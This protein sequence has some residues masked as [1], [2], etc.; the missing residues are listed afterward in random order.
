[1]NKIVIIG[2]GFSGLV[3]AISAK[4]DNNEVTILEKRNIVG[5][6]ILVTGNGRCNYYNEVQ[7]NKFYHS[8]NE[9]FVENIKDE[10]HKVLE[11]YNNLGI[12][13]FIKDGYY[14]PYSK[15]ASTI[16]NALENRCKELNIKI[17]TDYKVDSV[18]KDNNEFVIN[19]DIRC[20][21]VII[22]TGSLAYYKDEEQSLGYDIAKSFGHHIVKLLPSL[23]Q[24]KGEGNYFKEWAGVRSDAIVSLYVDNYLVSKE[25]GEVM[26][27]DYG[28]SG[29]CIFN[30]SGHASRSLDLGM[31]V[32]I[33]INFLPWLTENVYKYLNNRDR[34]IENVL[35]GM[36]N[37]KL[38][39]LIL[40]KTNIDKNK[41]FKELRDEDKDILVDYL[42]NFKVKITGVNGFDKA[43]VCSGGV[44]TKEVDKNTY[45]SKLVKGLYFAG[46]I[47]DVDGI[48][49]GYNITFATLSGIKAGIGAA[50]D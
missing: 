47:L 10:T 4:K 26:L 5:K 8:S 32:R 29:I 24:L 22:A 35:E 48:C 34:S 14:Y 9:E 37:S 27:T 2:G 45:E 11:F 20:N 12:V 3:S 7:D 13:P 18:I 6:K 1:M 42:L 44:D 21:K 39:K 16:R 38:V 43:Q 17:I 33:D 30:L 46:E 19:N 28:L 36:L 50:N 49:G 31:D 40:N 23:V 25:K 41:S 15:E